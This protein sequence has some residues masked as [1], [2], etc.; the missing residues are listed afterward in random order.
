MTR[1]V[2]RACATLLVGG[3]CACAALQQIAA[4]R[5]VS[6]ALAGVQQ[7]RLAGVALDRIASYR[8]LTATEIAR[9]ALAIASKDLP[10][11]FRL[12]VQAENPADNRTAATLVR[13]AWSLYL[14]D[15]ETIN[16]VLDTTY[17]LPPGQP[18][19]FPLQMTLNLLQFF[20]GP[21]ES[22]AN[23]AAGLAGLRADPTRIALRAVPSI[24]TPLG[25]ISYPSSITIVSR[26]VGGAGSPGAAAPTPSR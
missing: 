4:L 9:L 1:N 26:T 20:D 7:G 8:D 21:A 23:L 19:V 16:G 15:K 18:V 6:F 3:L 25:P 24:D 13:L 2:R 11:A 22:L 5:R 10:L 12:D 14:D 17:T